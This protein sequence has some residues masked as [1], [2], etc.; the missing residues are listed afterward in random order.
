MSFILTYDTLKS[1]LPVKLQINAD[2]YS[3]FNDNFDNWIALATERIYNDI[4]ENLIFMQVIS[5]TFVPNGNGIILKPI[6]W[7]SDLSFIAINPDNKFIV[8]KQRDYSVLR[9]ILEAPDNTGFP[10]YYAS[11]Y[12]YLQYL[13][14][15]I[16][17][18]PYEYEVTFIQQPF[19]IDQNNTTNV[20]TVYMSKVFLSAMLLE[21]S[22]DLKYVDYQTAAAQDYAATLNGW[23]K[24]NDKTSSSAATN[25]KA[26]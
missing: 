18:A 11:Q 15:P 21:A 5:G 25:R 22:F 19:P 2:A 7:R 24:V 17:D 16:P 3:Y 14:A 23:I 9:R 6:N 13:I 10:T 26:I 20:L 4:P 8:L 12:G 1:I